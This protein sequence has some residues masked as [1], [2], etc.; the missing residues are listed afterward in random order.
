MTSK[1]SVKTAILTVSEHDLLA[2]SRGLM[3]SYGTAAH[4][5]ASRRAAALKH[6]GDHDGAAIWHDVA[7]LIVR[8]AGQ[9]S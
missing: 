8:E 7:G 3:K 1:H 6:C 5:Y 9:T 4:G 2:Y